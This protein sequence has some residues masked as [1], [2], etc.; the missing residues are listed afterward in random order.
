MH[1][2]EDNL[3]YLPEGFI[4]KTENDPYLLYADTDSAYLL[5]D[6][7]FDKFEN[8]HQLVSYIQKL[9]NELGEIYNDSLNYYVGT[10]ANMNPKYNTMDFKSE[11]VAYKGFM[12][13]KKFYALSKCWDEGTFFE[14]KPKL[15]TTGGQIKKSDVT[16]ITK[17]LLDEVY[18]LLVTDLSV[19]DLDYMY[20]KIFVEFTSTYR[21]MILQD[22]ADLNFN[23]FS[24][25]KKWGRTENSVPTH[26]YGAKFFNAIVDDQFRPSDSFL[27]VKI[28]CEMEKVK[29]YLF[30][31]EMEKSKYCLSYN[32]AVMLGDKLN[33]ICIPPNMSKE[34][35]EKFLEKMEQ[36]NIKLNYDEIIN[37]N[38]NMKL[39]PFQDLFP[40]EVKMRVL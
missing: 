1:I 4:E 31:H 2:A 30:E 9:A 5:Y 25:P 35:K 8:I 16:Q 23:S 29:H 18:K 22:I 32:E 15:K 3:W 10:F 27:I 33:V 11:V 40:Y 28:T 21:E 24:I 20:H 38:I 26:V 19:T 12:G 17:K 13:A 39:D 14:E 37:F 36:F 34:Q 7:P 6:L